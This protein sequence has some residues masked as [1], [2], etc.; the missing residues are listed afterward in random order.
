[1]NKSDIVIEL[2]LIR[3]VTSE[4]NVKLLEQLESKWFEYLQIRTAI[5]IWKID[6]RNLNYSNF[7]S[8]AREKQYNLSKIDMEELYLPP[9]ANSHYETCIDILKRKW[10]Q[11]EISEFLTNMSNRIYDMSPEESH[12]ELITYFQNQE[13]LEQKKNKRITEDF[14][15]ENVE[16]IVLGGKSRPEL[17]EIVPLKGS[18]ITLAGDSGHH[19]SNQLL[20][21]LL[22]FL[23]NNP[24]KKAVFFSKEMEFKEVQARLYANRLEYDFKSILKRKD[25][26]NGSKIDVD[27]L[28]ADMEKYHQHICENF[29]VISPQEFQ[30]NSD[31]ARILMQYE[32]DVW[33]LDFL[34]WYAQVQ[35]GNAAEQ[36]RNVM[37]TIAFSKTIS[38]VTNSLGIILSQVRKRS[39]FRTKVFPRIDDIE[40]SGLTKQI[41]HSI[42]MCFWP[43]KHENKSEK[44]WYVTSWQKVRNGDLFNEP[45]WIDPEMCKFKY[46]H[47]PSLNEQQRRQRINYLEM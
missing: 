25:R 28:T 7:C 22:R 5:E 32:P 27:K 38:Q 10:R 42:G 20:D 46:P 31:I 40:W 44:N 15:D 16:L 18:V 29:I 12:L 9:H 24:T 33:G 8:F 13:L 41:S 4:Q 2:E 36:N 19:K 47:P 43:Y 6:H 23:D 37:E 17:D 1:M 35:A 34:Q 14:T 30:S 26:H 45:A 11:R 3:I 21:M 39:D